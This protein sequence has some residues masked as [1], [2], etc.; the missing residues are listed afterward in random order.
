MDRRIKYINV[1]VALHDKGFDF[2]VK[3][4]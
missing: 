2:L 3:L 1:L 4:T